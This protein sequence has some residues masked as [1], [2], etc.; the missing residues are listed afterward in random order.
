MITSTI[1]FFTIS[2][3]I[4]CWPTQSIKTSSGDHFN[5]DGLQLEPKEY[6]NNCLLELHLIEQ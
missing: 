3:V 5:E 1:I 6:L 4:L 2:F